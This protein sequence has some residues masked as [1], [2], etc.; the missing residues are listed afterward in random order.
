MFVALSMGLGW[1]AF[2]S[3]PALG[4]A[5]GSG[6]SVAI[7]MAAMFTPALSSVLTRL[8]TREGFQ[9]MYLRPHFKGHIKPYMLIYLGPTALILLSAAIYFLIFPGSFDP[10]LSRLTALMA[11][12]NETGL[13]APALLAVQTA[14]MVVIG[15]IVNIIPTMG[16]ELGWRGYLLPKLRAFCSD[17]AALVLSGVVW[18]VWHWPVIVLGHNYGTDYPAYPWLGILAMILFCVAL[19]II[20][21][22]ASIRLKSAVPA[23]MIHS[24]VNAGAGLPIYLSIGDQNALLGPAIT[25]VVGG[26]PLIA[27]AVI[28]FIKSDGRA[29][30][31]GVRPEGL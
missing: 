16:E 5:Y 26:L 14:Q 4:L 23:A 6:P 3:I 24:A 7:L 1:A 11:Q 29:P 8:I 28:L 10:A 12:G 21:G 22:Y 30:E 20:E 15:P 25:G 13:S 9:N 17:R 27:L 18:G 2:L 19:G 31:G